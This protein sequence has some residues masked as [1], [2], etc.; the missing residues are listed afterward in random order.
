MGC[1]VRKLVTIISSTNGIGSH[2]AIP[3]ATAYGKLEWIYEKL[4]LKLNRE[5]INESGRHHRNAWWTISMSGEAWK[6]RKA[7]S[8]QQLNVKNDFTTWNLRFARGWCVT[9]TCNPFTE[10]S[11]LEWRKVLL[12]VV[13][14]APVCLRRSCGNFGPNF[15]DSHKV[16]L[17]SKYL[18]A[19]DV[20]LF[21]VVI[22]KMKKH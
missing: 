10:T 20:N 8:A 5:A 3:S 11:R 4:N 14:L 2:L 16:L 19:Q 22:E 9:R 7:S 17:A 18:P 6:M 21:S 13:S 1:V 12:F 15:K